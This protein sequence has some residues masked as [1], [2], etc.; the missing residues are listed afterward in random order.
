MKYA[1]KRFFRSIDS[2]KDI[3]LFKLNIIGKPIKS[4]KI[5]P[6]KLTIKP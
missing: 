2:R 4:Q 6:I 1:S 5:N 3:K